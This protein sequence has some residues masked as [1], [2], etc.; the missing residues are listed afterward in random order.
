MGTVSGKYGLFSHKNKA[1]ARY[2]RLVSGGRI[3][4]I[5]GPGHDNE[6]YWKQDGEKLQLVSQD[7]QVTAV[8]DCLHQEEGYSYWEGL[9][10]GLVPLELRLFEYRSDLFDFKTKFTSRHLID[11]GALTVGPHTY[12][13]PL[14]VDYDHGGQVIIG[15]YCSIGQNV[16]FVTANHD[17][18]LVTTYPFKSLQAFYTDT[19]LALADDHILK[20][21]TRVGN[22]VWIGNNVQIMAG[23]SIG[24]GAVIAA[25]SVVTKDVEPY[26]IVG[27]NPARP[28]RYRISDPKERQAMQKIAWWNWSE[29]VI[30]QRLDQI[31]SK[32]ITGFIANYLPKEAHEDKEGNHVS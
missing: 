1:Q 20:S 12:G 15:D 22:D 23:V 21:P 4:D 31:M 27:G 25:G 9:H 17:L 8:F 6:R 19:G 11:Y 10:Q 24:D 13:I 14:L 28:I 26:Q 32:D 3:Q 2:F 5:G 18:D 7:G 16:Y 30:A 29:E